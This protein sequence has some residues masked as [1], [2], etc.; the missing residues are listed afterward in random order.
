MDAE[1]LERINQLLEQDSEL[2]EVN[3]Q[4][5]YRRHLFS[6]VLIQKIRDQVGEFD[7]KTRTMSGILNRIHSTPSDAC[8]TSVILKLLARSDHFNSTA[9][10]GL[11]DT[12][13]GELSGRYSCARQSCSPESILAVQ[14]LLVKLAS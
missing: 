14:R 5:S 8:M 12:G 11:S 10:A 7:K 2:R 3:I 4:C 1:N 6:C 9:R 13:V